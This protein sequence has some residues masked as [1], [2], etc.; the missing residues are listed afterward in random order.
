MVQYNQTRTIQIMLVPCI[1]TSLIS[2]TYEYEHKNRT[3]YQ[4]LQGLR[5]LKKLE[6]SITPKDSDP[7]YQ[8]YASTIDTG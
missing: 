1:V 5:L 2:L 3:L 6:D 8:F 4:T 7:M